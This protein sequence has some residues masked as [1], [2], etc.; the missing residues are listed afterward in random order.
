MA[1]VQT[2]SRKA[3]HVSWA[4]VLSATDT[5]KRIVSALTTDRNDRGHP[6][7]CSDLFRRTYRLT[8]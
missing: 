1:A 2:Y 8:A 4:S 7:R 5:D 3:Y 6:A